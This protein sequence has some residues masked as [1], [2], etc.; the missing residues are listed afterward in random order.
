MSKKFPF[1]VGN[2][3][4]VMVLESHTITSFS[5]GMVKD[6]SKRGEFTVMH[7]NGVDVI[8]KVPNELGQYLLHK[9]TMSSPAHLRNVLVIPMEQTA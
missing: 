4:G 2:L 8:R 1:E 9:D 3:V 7:A 6:V 5:I